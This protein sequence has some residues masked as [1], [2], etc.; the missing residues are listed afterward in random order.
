VT[1]NFHDIR[2][3]VTSNE[4]RGRLVRLLSWLDAERERAASELAVTPEPRPDKTPAGVTIRT[5]ELVKRDALVV[6]IAQLDADHETARVWL[7]ECETNQ[8]WSI[9]LE[10]SRWLHRPTLAE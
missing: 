3:A 9:G 5:P 7:L 10:L 1:P 4:M 6:R 8:A 2:F